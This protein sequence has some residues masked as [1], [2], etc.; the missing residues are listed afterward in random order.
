MKYEDLSFEIND[1]GI[2]VRLYNI[3]E[4][5]IPKNELDKLDNLKVDKNELTCKNEKKIDFLI[6]KY[7]TSL[8]NTISGKPALYIHSNSE[9]PLMG[10]NYFG[11]VDRGSNIIE[12]KPLTSCNLNCVFCSVDEGIDSKKQI[13]FVIEKDYLI[14]EFKKITNFKKTDKI[15]ALI[16]PQGEPLLYARLGELIADLNKIKEVETISMNTN[17]TMLTKS[18]IDELVKAGLTRINFSL[19]ALDTKK[20]DK[21]AGTKYNVDRVLE[22]IE[23]ASK[24]VDINIAPVWVDGMNDTDIEDVIEFANSLKT[25][26]TV[27]VG[28]Q[29]MLAHKFGR[30]PAKQIE[31]E[32]FEKRIKKLEKKHRIDLHGK[33]TFNFFK[34]KEFNKPFKK[35]DNITIELISKGRLNNEMLGKSSDRIVSIINCHHNIGKKLKVKIIRSKHN[36]FTAV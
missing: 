36:I 14:E 23:Y 33:S 25:K 8:K 28:I 30:K 22:V 9:I 3:F 16:N 29:N 11:L 12:L 27:F 21:L 20:A 34:T 17:G 26:K 1:K 2:N 15:E 19:N 10:T 24:L 6:S 18:R 31:W 32:D 13:D 7:I 35:G 5:L 4:F